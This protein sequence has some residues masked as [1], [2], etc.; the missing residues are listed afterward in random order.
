VSLKKAK[1]GAGTKE[2]KKAGRQAGTEEKMKR[3]DETQKQH[4]R[5]TQSMQNACYKQVYGVKAECIGR[6]FCCFWA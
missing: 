4:T 1:P 5:N 3:K 2:R 6:L